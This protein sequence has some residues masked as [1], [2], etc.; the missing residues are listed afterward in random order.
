MSRTKIIKINP[1]AKNMGKFNQS[2]TFRNRKTDYQRKEKH[3]GKLDA[4]DYC[5]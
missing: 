2:K 1:V 4:F 5:F 3:S